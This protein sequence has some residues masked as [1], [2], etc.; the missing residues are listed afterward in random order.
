M[1]WMQ[2]I[3]VGSQSHSPPIT[4]NYHISQCLRS[5]AETRGQLAMKRLSLLDPSPSTIA[6][7]QV[8]GF[9]SPFVQ[10]PPL[11]EATPEP[12][13]VS[14]P[15]QMDEGDNSLNL[16]N[17]DSLSAFSKP[18]DKELLHELLDCNI[19][20]T[21]MV[22]IPYYL[23]QTFARWVPVAPKA[24]LRANI[25]RQLETMKPFKP[26]PRKDCTNR[27]RRWYSIPVHLPR[28]TWV[29]IPDC[30][31]GNGMGLQSGH[32]QQRYRNSHDWK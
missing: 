17:P 31:A 8:H 30:R 14:W 15:C 32:P 1:P 2:N 16:L 26:F 12:M 13:E 9:H 6:E 11:E 28:S 22:K 18:D 3:L 24:M 20:F 29:E 10:L 7:N 27:E 23:P 21:P 5:E 25:R 4:A 19:G